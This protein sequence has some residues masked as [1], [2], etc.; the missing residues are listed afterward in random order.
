M[1]PVPSVLACAEDKAS[2][3]PGCVSPNRFSINRL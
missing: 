2:G 1:N 3:V